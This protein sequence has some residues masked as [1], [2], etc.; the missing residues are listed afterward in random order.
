VALA[1]A[2]VDAATEAVGAEPRFARDVARLIAS[3]GTGVLL[4]AAVAEGSC[5]CAAAVAAI[6][7]APAVLVAALEERAPEVVVVEEASRRRELD[8]WGSIARS[9][10]APGMG[11]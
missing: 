10:A 5:A 1:D 2:V 3:G 7:A 9:S 11:L 6:A 8:V 4:G